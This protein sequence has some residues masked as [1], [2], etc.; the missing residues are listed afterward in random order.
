MILLLTG[1]QVKIVILVDGKVSREETDPKI[2]W[3]AVANTDTK[4]ETGYSY[5]KLLKKL[6][7]LEILYYF[8]IKMI[9]E[10]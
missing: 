9:K 8:S 3:K 10:K 6:N 1:I 4:T 2:S 7:F 5:G